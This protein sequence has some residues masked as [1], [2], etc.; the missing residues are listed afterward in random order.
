MKSIIFLPKIEK[1]ILEK[2]ERV[3]LF[4]SLSNY[5]GM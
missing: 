4:V 5:E 3:K 2:I 1:N